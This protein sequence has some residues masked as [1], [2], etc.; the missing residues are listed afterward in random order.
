[1]ILCRSGRGMA[2]VI[3]HLMHLTPTGWGIFIVIFASA[4]LLTYFSRKILGRVMV[5]K[6]RI[7]FPEFQWVVMP[8]IGG[9]LSAIIFCILFSFLGYFSSIAEDI[10]FFRFMG[11]CCA[12]YCTFIF[13]IIPANQSCAIL[14]NKNELYLAKYSGFGRYRPIKDLEN[15]TVFEEVREKEIVLRIKRGKSKLKTFGYITPSQFTE[16]GKLKIQEF[17]NYPSVTLNRSL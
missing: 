7:Q 4:I 3:I 8:K 5:A 16:G 2:D 11:L 6:A 9:K 1:M 14:C 13:F 12:A 17:I 10:F 15:I